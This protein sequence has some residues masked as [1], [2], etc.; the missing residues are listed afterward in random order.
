MIKW[1]PNILWYKYHKAGLSHLFLKFRLIHKAKPYYMLNEKKKVK[2][3]SKMLTIKGWAN[4]YHENT[5]SKKAGMA[6]LGINRGEF[7]P[8]ISN[9]D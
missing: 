2:N 6:T 3:N 7:R 8:K 4:V 1:R 5:N 9:R